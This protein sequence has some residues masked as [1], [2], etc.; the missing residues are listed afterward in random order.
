MQET[1][2]YL[3]FNGNCREA[4][5]FY[6]KCLGIQPQIMSFGDAPPGTP[7]SPETKDKVM[8]A[9]IGQGAKTY[10]MASDNMPGMPF[11]QGNNFSINI[12]CETADELD[13]F[14]KALISDGGKV[15]MPP[16]ETFW[17]ARFGMG[18]DKFGINWMFNLEK[19]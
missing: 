4:M 16:G 2:P 3:I 15:T 13:R 17:A 5:S 6:G 1:N 19:K 14:F 7:S 11:T 8:H 18:T 12:Q 9:R 10:L